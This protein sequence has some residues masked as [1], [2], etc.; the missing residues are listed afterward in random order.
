MKFET[1]IEAGTITMR[2]A[3]GDFENG[4]SADD[5][6][7]ALNEHSGGPVKI[8]LNSEGG[9]VT[10]GLSMYNAIMQHDGEVTIHIDT[11]AASIATVISAAADKVVMNSN[12]KYMI[13]CAWTIAAGNSTEFKNMAQILDMMD[14]DIADAYSQ[15]TGGSPEEML[16]MMKDETWMDAEVAFAQ[17]F[18]DEVY[19]VER[20]PAAKTVEKAFAMAPFVASKASA[21]ARRMKLRLKK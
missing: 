21:T 5:F 15:R 19:K 20:L 4:I 3:I 7:D 6:R 18:V 13:H 16:A 1:D 11:I 8:H 17:G 10:D 2:G 9:S 14:K 12:A